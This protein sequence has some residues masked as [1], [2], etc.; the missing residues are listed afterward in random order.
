MEYFKII[1]K[2]ISKLNPLKKFFFLISELRKKTLT[3]RD[4]K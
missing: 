2:I 3:M 1:L 4:F